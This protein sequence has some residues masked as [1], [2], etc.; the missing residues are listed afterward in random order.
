MWQSENLT[1]VV[2]RI[3]HIIEHGQLNSQILIKSAL[4]YLP[5]IPPDIFDE[6]ITHKHL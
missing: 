5:Q 2:H 1:V 3:S 4:S 6:L